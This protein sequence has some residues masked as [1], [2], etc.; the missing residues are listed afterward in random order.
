M[1]RPNTSQDGFFYV[2]GRHFSRV[3]QA[4]YTCLAADF[5]CSAAD[6]TCSAEDSA[7]SDAD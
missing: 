2:F 6:Y 7:C 5:T 3:R 4:I 1:R